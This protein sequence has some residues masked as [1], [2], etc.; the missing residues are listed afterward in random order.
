MGTTFKKL[1]QNLMAWVDGV[2]PSFVKL[3]TQ[4]A[5]REI[6]DE[7][8]WGFLIENS[9]IRTPKLIGN[10][11][12]NVT[13]FSTSVVL[14]ATAK[15]LVDAIT[16]DMVPLIERQFRTLSPVAQTGKSFVYNITDYESG[17]GTLT[18]NPAYQDV[19]KVTAT[20]QIVKMYYAPPLYTPVGGDPVI[21]FK[22][23]E[24]VVSPLWQRRI[25]L[26][27][28]Q[29]ELNRFDPVRIWLDEPRH[30]VP[31]AYKIDTD[32]NEIPLFEFYPAPSQERVFRV[33]YRRLGTI[34]KLDTEIIPFFNPEL[35]LKKARIKAYEWLIANS[36]K[37][38]T[39]KT[40]GKFQNLIAML[41]NPNASD[42][43]PRL[44]EK[45]IALDTDAMNRSFMGDFLEG[46]DSYGN[47]IYCDRGLNG[48]RI[49]STL[50]LSF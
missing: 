21:D 13:Q 10:G 20:Y 36:D 50:V 19:S 25:W 48:D 8:D 11:T 27:S 30:L 7:H 47:G 29:E 9:F 18:I 32:G 31:F 6:Y 34:P 46:N 35:I 26:D 41:M 45:A 44:L 2:P 4:Q 28:T 42:S 39:I 23:W 49:G 3:I 40:T 43:Y 14:D 15:A 1:Y 24:F 33:Q 37:S 17:T 22:G 38:I 16:V 12:A 5:I